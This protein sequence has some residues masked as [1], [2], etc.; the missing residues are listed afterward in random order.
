ML[1]ILKY[2]G[3]ILVDNMDWVFRRVTDMYIKS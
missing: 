3:Y 1:E 2:L